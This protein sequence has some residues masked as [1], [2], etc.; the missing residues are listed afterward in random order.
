MLL[1]NALVMTLSGCNNPTPA[2]T[3]SDTSTTTTEGTDTDAT[4]TNATPATDPTNTTPPTTTDPGTDTD[5]T[6]PTTAGPTTEPSTDTD[7]DTQGTDTDTTTG[8]PVIEVARVWVTANPPLLEQDRIV[9]LTPALDAA[10]ATLSVA[11]DV[12][13]IQSVA[14][15]QQGHAYIT[16]DAPGATGGVIVKN[17]LAD[18]PADG[19]LGLGDR[20]IHGPATGLQTPKGVE[21][22]P[23]NTILVA[24]TGA[25]AIK[26]FAND[27]EGDAAPLFEITDLGSS[28]AIWDVHYAGGNADVLYAAGTNGEVQVY[29]DF[30]NSMGQAGPDRTIVP[31]EGGTKVSVNLHG[32]TVVGNNLFLSD[33]GDPMETTDG[34]LFRI[35]DPADADG[36]VEVAQR[37]EGGDLGNPVDLE[38]TG[39]NQ[40]TLWVAEKANGKLLRYRPALLSEDYDLVDGVDVAAPESVALATNNR[41]ILASNPAGLDTDAVLEVEVPIIGAPN[42]TATIDRLGSITS[43]QSI[44]LV[45]SDALVG[46][47]GTPASDGGGVFAAAGIAD[48]ADGDVV[49]AIGTRIWG[50]ATGLVA[51]KGMTLDA[52]GTRL[53]V[54]DL[55][56]SSI[57]VFDPVTF[58]DA[59]PVFVFA[60]LGGGAVWDIDYDDANDR[61]FAAGVDGTVRVFDNAL[62]DEGANGP[63]RTFTPA[64]DEDQIIGVNLHGIQYDPLTKTLILSDVGDAMSDT[65]GA[66]FLVADADTAEGNV[67]VTAVIAGDQTHL[68]NPVDLAFDGTHLYVA[69]KAQSRVLRYSDILGLSGANNVAE[70]AFFEVTNPESVRI[71]FTK[72]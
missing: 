18:N 54:A 56:D 66:I 33:V 48:L 31:V 7:T 1:A 24:D 23:D 9:A 45:G 39:G 32:I 4:E 34:Q 3:D 50:P 19:P 62:S 35:A 40:S 5:T 15:T 42:V 11:G 28:E 2:D 17:D 65:D 51:P 12:V 46:F 30:S 67:A 52:A 20:V 47:D 21:I 29:E 36:D 22:G 25:A 72:P 68:G 13:S 8:E 43:V 27:A 37:I 55:G 26:V 69:E 59:P 58:G 63:A 53:F 64:N 70:D 60:E 61:L 16:Y 14:V 57:K 41:L 38:V 49:D 10:T 71:E 6:A 44:A